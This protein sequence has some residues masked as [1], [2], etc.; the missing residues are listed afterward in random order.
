VV[1]TPI[2]GDK[3]VS[4]GRASWE[5]WQAKPRTLKLLTLSA[6]PLSRQMKILAGADEP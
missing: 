6:P 2:K 1:L 3:D 5:G 4:V